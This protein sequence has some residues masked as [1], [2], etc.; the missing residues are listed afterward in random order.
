MQKLDY[1]LRF[2][3]PR[4]DIFHNC[5]RR[6]SGQ[7]LK[8]SSCNFIFCSF[9]T[10][11][12][13]CCVWV[14]VCAA[15]T[16]SFSCYDCY[17]FYLRCV[18]VCVCVCPAVQLLTPTAERRSSRRALH[19]PCCCWRL[20]SSVSRRWASLGPHTEFINPCGYVYRLL[21]WFFFFVEYSSILN[22]ETNIIFLCD[23]EFTEKFKVST[24]FLNFLNLRLR[25]VQ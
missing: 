19:L 16:V 15:S 12:S 22:T 2:A 14:C 9:S 1:I 25:C 17:S 3:C 23:T 4:V 11:F 13:L 8:L 24:N 20:F 18:F 5:N 6:R 10:S 21:S 7:F